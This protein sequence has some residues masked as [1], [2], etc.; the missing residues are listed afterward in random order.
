MS[1]VAARPAFTPQAARRRAAIF[2]VMLVVGVGIASWTVR[3]PAVRDLLHASTAEMGLVLFGISV[4]SMTGVLSSAAIVRSRGAQFTVAVGGS[5]FVAG[6]ALIG[7][8]A[9]AALDAGVFTGL[10]FV[11][12]GAGLMEIALNVEGAAIETESHRSVLPMMHG[13]FSLGTVVGAVAGIGLTAISF[14]VVWHM[15]GV[16]IGGAAIVFWAVR[17]VPAETGRSAGPAPA[18]GGGFRAQLGLWRQRRVLMLGLIVLALALAEGSA[19]DWLP[20]LMVDGHGASPALGSVIFTGFA[21]AMT[22]GRFAGEP[23]LARFGNA[24]VL[25]VSAL[26]SAAGIA[27][28]V[29]ADNV[30]VAGLAV[31]LWGLGAALGFPV[32]L[33]AAAE[34]PDPTSTVGAVASA[35]YVAFLVGPPLLG[36]LGDHVGLRGAMIVVLVV[37]AA[38]ATLTSAAKPLPAG[39]PS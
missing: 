30:I 36:F 16:A 34:S 10:A 31:A 39:S 4:G 9:A 6:M 20:L 18:A 15:S 17:R 35:G 1:S 32:T 19:N 22:A 2:A 21:L 7:I 23:L 29:F 13:F 8:G 14:P 24:A 5:A 11:G 37:V 27:T 3:T 12:L 25:R 33:S 26:V 38:A 28:V